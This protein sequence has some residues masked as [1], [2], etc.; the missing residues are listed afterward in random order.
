MKLTVLLADAAQEAP[1]GKLSALGLGWTRITAPVSGF[2][3]LG[4]VELD[5]EDLDHPRTVVLTLAD[6][7]GRPIMGAPAQEMIRI[8]ISLDAPEIPDGRDMFEPVRLQFVVP[9][10]PGLPIPPGNYQ[11]RAVADDL[12]S[13]TASYRFCVVQQMSSTG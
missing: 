4:L 2:A 13:T 11:F 1:H 9:I 12:D 7:D 10:P 3:I 8:E 5:N 6:A